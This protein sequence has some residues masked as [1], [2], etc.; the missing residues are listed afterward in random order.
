MGSESIPAEDGDGALG[1]LQPWREALCARLCVE[2]W[3]GLVT[4]SGRVR[5]PVLLISSASSS[6]RIPKPTSVSPPDNLPF[7]RLLVTFTKP[8]AAAIPPGVGTLDLAVSVHDDPIPSF[9][10]P[11]S[12]PWRHLGI[13]QALPQGCSRRGEVSGTS[14]ASN[15]HPP[16]LLLLLQTKPIMVCILHCLVQRVLNRLSSLSKMRGFPITWFG[17][18]FF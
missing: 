18:F 10:C 2:L 1:L 12:C 4:R 9:L 3:G 15:N 11:R 13:P 5:C 16:V 17:F 14:T 6:S 7:L 8:Y